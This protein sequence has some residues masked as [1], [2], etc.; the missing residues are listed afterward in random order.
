MMN[1]TRILLLLPTILLVRIY[2][3]FAPIQETPETFTPTCS[4]TV[5]S[6]VGNEA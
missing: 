3:L 4:P 2:R 6:Q 1:T 5:S